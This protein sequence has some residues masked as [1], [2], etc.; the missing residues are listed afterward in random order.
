MS[1]KS[2]MNFFIII[3]SATLF[4]LMLTANQGW[5]DAI[6]DIANSKPPEK[7]EVKVIPYTID[8]IITRITNDCI[9]NNIQFDTHYE[10]VCNINDGKRWSWRDDIRLIAFDKENFGDC[11]SLYIHTGGHLLYETLSYLFPKYNDEERKWE[12]AKNIKEGLEHLNNTE[13]E[14]CNASIVSRFKSILNKIVDA[15][16]QIKTAVQERVAYEAQKKKCFQSDEYNIYRAGSSAKKSFQDLD[17]AKKELNKM[18]ASGKVI[19]DYVL[20]HIAQP[21]MGVAINLKLSFDEYKMYGGKAKTPQ[22][23]EKTPNPCAQYETVNQ[24]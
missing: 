5:A 17:M 11:D 13:R 8:E 12:S 2:I 10:G 3:K 7:P 20:A 9:D 18:R 6:D 23:I 24:K 19:P 15:A 21:M 22:S 1:K 14:E 4:L 16:P